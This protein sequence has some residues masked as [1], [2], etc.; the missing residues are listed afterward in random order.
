MKSLLTPSC[1]K[2]YALKQYGVADKI[3]NVI[4]SAYKNGTAQVR[5]QR[6]SERIYIWKGVCQGDTLSPVMF[7]AVIVELLK[8]VKMNIGLNINGEKLNHPR[9]TDDNILFAETKEQ[10]LK[11]PR[12]LNE[13]EKKDE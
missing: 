7:T 5:T 6:L 8:R 11:L 9:F 2:Q 1:T 4:K 12:R 10:P 13:E 3:I